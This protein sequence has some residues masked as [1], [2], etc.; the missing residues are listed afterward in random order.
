MTAI[1]VTMKLVLFTDNLGSGGA[2]SQLC[3]LAREFSKA[4]H[5]VLVLTYNSDSYAAGRFF[6]PH[7]ASAGIPHQV[8]PA[9]FRGARPLALR[10]FLQECAPDAVLAFQEAPALY[11]ELARLGWSP[12][13]GLV[14]SERSA[15]PGSDSGWRAAIR[16]GHHAASY[17]VCNSETN[18]KLMEDSRVGLRGSI[19]TIYNAVDLDHFHPSTEAAKRQ[20]DPRLRLAVL[21]SYQP[22]KNLVKVLAAVRLLVGRGRAPRL[23]WYG[24]LRDPSVLSEGRRYVQMY[25]LGEYVG[26][27][28]A[29][30]DAVS[31]CR[32]VDAVV[33]ASLYEG[34]PN[35][36]CEAMA[37]GRPVLASRVCDIPL[38]V[39]EEQ[40]GLLF[41]PRSPASIAGAIER[42]AQLPV[43][44]RNAWGEAARRR[45]ERL[46]EPMRCADQYLTLLA[47]SRHS[48]GWRA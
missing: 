11:A 27:H 4:G 32:S 43:A 48:K 17:I 37:C 22:L 21:A 7:L 25:G 38:L 30:T 36:V 16:A 8:L 2:Q 42:F 35:T 3:L 13:W 15:V 1:G 31:V 46:F 6:E 23:D 24:G 19:R 39:Q 47:T 29:T 44:T 18:R 10:R 41:D 14:V 34:C 9:A 45:A 12:K 28:D 26:L 5:E 33:L 20:D 40:T